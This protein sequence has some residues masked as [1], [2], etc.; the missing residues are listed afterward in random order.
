M[1]VVSKTT[2]QQP[3][4]QVSILEFVVQAHQGP[5]EVDDGG[6]HVVEHQEEAEEQ[7]KPGGP[8]Q[9]EPFQE[10]PPTLTDRGLQF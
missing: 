4:K 9:A 10:A 3:P 5:F 2:V 6:H 8:D 7:Q 1:L